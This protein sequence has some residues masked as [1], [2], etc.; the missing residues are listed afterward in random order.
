[1]WLWHR[2]TV[3]RP[4]PKVVLLPIGTTV[5]GIEKIGS[6]YLA[7]QI[8]RKTKHPRF[9]NWVKNT[10]TDIAGICVNKGKT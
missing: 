2:Y 1:M 6:F 8:S 4:Y 3:V 7:Q 9:E 5:L 10:Y